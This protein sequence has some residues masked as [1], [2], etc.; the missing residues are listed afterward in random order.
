M[1]WQLRTAELNALAAGA[2]P[3]DRALREL[4]ALQASDWAFLATSGPPA[5]T[6][7][8]GPSATPMRSPPRW[9]AT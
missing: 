3:S 5:S 1:A 4:L 8:S 6:R 7:A 2:R 9:R